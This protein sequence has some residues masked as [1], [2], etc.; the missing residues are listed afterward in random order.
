MRTRIAVARLSFASNRINPVITSATDLDADI[1]GF[2]AELGA[3]ESFR[4]ENP[5]ADIRFHVSASARAGGVLADEVWTSA[6]EA[7]LGALGNRDFDAVLLFLD[8]RTCTV[9]TDTPELELVRAVR[10]CIGDRPLGLVLGHRANLGS[11]LPTHVDIAVASRDTDPAR[12]PR[13]AVRTVLGELIRRCKGGARLQHA[14]GQTPFTLAAAAVD[15]A[16]SVMAD[17]EAGSSPLASVFTGF[18]YSDVPDACAR[19]LAWASSRDDALAEVRTLGSRFV[20]K[21]GEFRLGLPGPNIALRRA[22]AERSG[23]TSGM[24]LVTDPADAPEYGGAC[25]STGLLRALLALQPEEPV[26]F[27][28]LADSAALDSAYLA[29]IGKT[30]DLSLGARHSRDFGAA[31]DVRAHVE[32]LTPA[33]GPFGRSALVSVGQVKI[34]IAER[35]AIANSPDAIAMLSP[36]LTRMGLLVLKAGLRI[37]PQLGALARSII[38]CD[39]PGPAALDVA[40][41]T[42]KNLRAR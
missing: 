8:G 9:S 22:F 1:T 36:E 2:P 24:I 4:E 17:I 23:L 7:L 3:V 19:I 16:E 39:T 11:E 18:P 29:G 6:S 10:N 27:A 31:I 26:G 5:D 32:G 42:L 13:N 35:T 30:V 41:L 40:S 37:S 12:H 25:D 28:Y 14:L 34:A 20:E 21:R 33:A 38:P 15:N